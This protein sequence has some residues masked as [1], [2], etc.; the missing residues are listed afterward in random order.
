[1]KITTRKLCLS[2]LLI[3]LTCVA[4]MVIRIPIPATGGYINVGDSMVLVCGVFFGPFFGV[5][6]G[7]IGSA[8]ADLLGGY[9]QYA[10]FTLIVKGVEGFIAAKIAGSIVKSDNF[11][12]VRRIIAS[13]ASVIW[14]IVGYFF[15]DW[16]LGDV[17]AATGSIIGNAVQAGG[18]VVI[19]FVVGYALHK[20]NIYAVSKARMV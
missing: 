10:L 16:I 11:F 7:G 2:A 1:M 13:F 12:S 15:T 8:L 18:S 14:M 20:A 5:V 17:A 9:T 4:T 19:F 6:C 3:A